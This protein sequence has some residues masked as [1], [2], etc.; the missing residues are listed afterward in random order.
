MRPE[1]ASRVSI[2]LADFRQNYFV[3]DASR[4]L[5]YL[6]SPG[7]MVPVGPRHASLVVSPLPRALHAGRSPLVLQLVVDVVQ[8]DLLERLG[9]RVEHREQAVEGGGAGGLHSSE[10]GGQA[11]SGE[12]GRDRRR[13][14]EIGRGTCSSEVAPS[15]DMAAMKAVY[16]SCLRSRPPST[17]SRLARCRGR[18]RAPA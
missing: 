11:R 18:R 5:V 12:I 10:A 4:F 2:T 16:S 17:P 14:R 3:S 8:V 1:N 6:E 13:S 7:T 15:C 9:P